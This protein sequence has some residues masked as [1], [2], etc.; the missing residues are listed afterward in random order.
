MSGPRKPIEP[1]PEE[2]RAAMFDHER[3]NPLMPQDWEYQTVMPDGATVLVSKVGGG[4]LGRYYAGAWHYNY[5]R[6]DR[7]AEGSDLV[8]PVAHTHADAAS[9]VADFHTPD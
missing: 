4:T 2:H 7:H 3:P 6:R 9:L 8:T 1:T 5:S